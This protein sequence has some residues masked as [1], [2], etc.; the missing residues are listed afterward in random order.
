MRLFP[1]LISIAILGVVANVSAS[2]A[3]TSPASTQN[4]IRPLPNPT[5]NSQDLQGLTAPIAPQ[6]PQLNPTLQQQ[7]QVQ[8]NSQPRESETVLPEWPTQGE[9]RSSGGG[10]PL[11]NF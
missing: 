3:N 5:G 8:P 2:R 9:P 4:Q 6:L 7:Y 10:V 11:F 1:L